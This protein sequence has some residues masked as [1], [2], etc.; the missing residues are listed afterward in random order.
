MEGSL[1]LI[2]TNM[3]SQDWVN[4]RLS[5]PDSQN[6]R[7]SLS[8]SSLFVINFN[9]LTHTDLL[10]P[11]LLL[12]FFPVTYIHSCS[13]MYGFILNLVSVRKCVL[14]EQIKRELVS[15]LLGRFAWVSLPGTAV[16]YFNICQMLNP[17]Q[18]MIT[19]HELSLTLLPLRQVEAAT[20]NGRY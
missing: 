17:L 3:F 16:C 4:V 12:S 15:S 7:R 1:G 9:T 18:L 2:S 5:F 13:Y 6:Q 10:I 19:Q 11:L 20:C 14:D 8:V